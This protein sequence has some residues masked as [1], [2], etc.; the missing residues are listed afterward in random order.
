MKTAVLDFRI[1]YEQMKAN[2][3]HGESC[4]C[5]PCRIVHVQH[6]ESLKLWE[7]CNLFK[8]SLPKATSNVLDKAYLATM[9]CVLVSKALKKVAEER[10]KFKQIKRQLKA[11]GFDNEYAG[12]KADAPN[13]AFCVFDHSEK[14]QESLRVCPG[15]DICRLL[16]QQ[17][18]LAK[19]LSW[20][21]MMEENSKAKRK[22]PRQPLYD[23]K[24]L[25]ELLQMVRG[26]RAHYR[27]NA[28][29]AKNVGEQ[30]LIHGSGLCITLKNHGQ[31]ALIRRSSLKT[32]FF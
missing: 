22:K 5:M 16:L 1:Q 2:V 8:E 3:A 18:Y 6:Y 20:Y 4:S 11:L 32:A 9:K 12:Q 15:I 31:S 25:T 17:L 27:A 21:L 26:F 13:N 10:T 19:N 14:I 23:D 28:S 30:A 24:E 29:T 7:F